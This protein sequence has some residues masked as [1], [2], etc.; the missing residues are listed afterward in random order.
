MRI[1]HVMLSKNFSGAERHVVELAAAQACEHEVHVILHAKGFGERENA[2]AHRFSNRVTVHKVGAPIRQWTFAQVR[3]KLKTLQPDII[4][5]HLKAAAKAVKGL[6]SSASKVATLHID[7]DPRQ[8]DH[9]DALI[10]I[11]PHQQ[12]RV[13]ARSSVA[14]VQIDNWVTGEAASREQALAVRRAHGIEDDC[15]LIGTIGRVEECKHHAL[16]IEAAMPLLN[17]SANGGTE[18]EAEDSDPTRTRLLSSQVKLAIVGTGRL[19]ESLKASHSQVI[20]PG[21]SSEAKAWMRAFDVFVSAADYEPFGLV[22]LEALQA[23]TPVVAT[24]TEG[25]QHLADALQITPLPINDVEALRNAIQTALTVVAERKGKVAQ[26]ITSG[27][28]N[29]N[30]SDQSCA[31]A[32]LNVQAFTL[33]EK[34]QQVLALYQQLQQLKQLK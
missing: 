10:A 34:N 12:Q 21:Y 9:M 15:L 28:C 17:E 33:E 32:A 5:C 22:F 1:V 31:N 27:S 11:T 2:I 23:Q 26:E 4:H 7:Y 18:I 19:Y 8:H 24:A 14:S 29:D 20:M 25:A 3:R 13:R 6:S 16:L 30:L